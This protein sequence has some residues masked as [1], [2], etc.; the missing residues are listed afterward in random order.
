MNI[1][2]VLA[3]CR[4]GVCISCDTLLTEQDTDHSICNA[5]WDLMEDDD[6]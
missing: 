4:T 1:Y 3:K 6:E 2:E 5:C